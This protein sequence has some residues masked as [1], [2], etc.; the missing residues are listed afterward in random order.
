LAIADTP[1]LSWRGSLVDTSRH[2][3]PVSHLLQH[4]DAMAHV[5]LNVFH[6]HLT[7]YQAFSLQLK[8]RPLLAHKGAHS[9]AQSYAA[10]DVK[11]VVA[12]A[13]A[14]GIRVIPEIDVPAHAGSWGL[15]FVNG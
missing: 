1:A 6:W 2:F 12:H 9:P 10:N 13:A 14:R 8:S 7:D 4:L 15:A 5:K 11:Q 3:V